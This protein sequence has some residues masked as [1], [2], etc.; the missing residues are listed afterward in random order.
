MLVTAYI[1]LPYASAEI[2]I[3]VIPNNR[4]WQ[5]QWRMYLPAQKDISNHFYCSKKCKYYPVHH[6]FHLFEIKQITES[7]G[8]KMKVNKLKHLSCTYIFSHIFWFNS[9]I[10]GVCWVKGTKYKPVRNATNTL[11]INK[12]KTDRKEQR[13]FLRTRVFFI[14]KTSYLYGTRCHLSH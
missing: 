14:G 4:I 6:P 8:K 1:K 11:K 7:A 9:F 12:W 13:Y 10:W 3:W 5:K 2:K